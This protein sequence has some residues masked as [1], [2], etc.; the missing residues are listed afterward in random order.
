MTN[1]FTQEEIEQLTK[2]FATSYIIDIVKHWNTPELLD[3]AMQRRFEL[4]PE[5]GSRLANT[6]IDNLFKAV[7]EQEV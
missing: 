7:L 6:P 2:M 1:K 5:Y 3:L 4:L